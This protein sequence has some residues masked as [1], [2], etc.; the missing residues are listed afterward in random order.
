MT[1]PR[2]Y[3]S[4]AGILCRLYAAKLEGMTND[5]VPGDCN[6]AFPSFGLRAFF[7]IRY[8]PAAPKLGE[9]GCLVISSS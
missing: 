9:G 2:K 4:F 7:V 1:K 8:S 5:Q 6:I 3:T